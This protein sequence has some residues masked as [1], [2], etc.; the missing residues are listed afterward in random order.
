M[1]F[2]LNFWA[3]CWVVG[4]HV[5]EL[6]VFFR[7][8]DG[9]AYAFSGEA[10]YDN[11]PLDKV[12]DKLLGVTAG[13]PYEVGLGVIHLESHG[14]EFFS[15]AFP[16]CHNSVCAGKQLVANGEGGAGG[17]EN[18]LAFK[19]KRKRVA[20]ETL[21]LD[22]D[23]GVKERRTVPP[24]PEVPPPRSE[25]PRPDPT[26]S[27]P[28]KASSPAPPVPRLFAGLGDLRQRGLKMAQNKNA[29]IDRQNLDF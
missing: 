20:I 17:G 2:P 21:H 1:S 11:F 18:N 12:V 22:T 8:G 15:D 4:Y 5:K 10:T 7:G 16:F 27:S 29:S 14:A 23:G 26:P 24:E 28:P 3:D 13:E 19:I 6:G 9:D 25:A